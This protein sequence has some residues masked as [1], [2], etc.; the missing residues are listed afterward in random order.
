MEHRPSCL[1]LLEGSPARAACE[2]L[3]PKEIHVEIMSMG[4][5][6]LFSGS[7]PM[8]S[9][10]GALVDRLPLDELGVDGKDRCHRFAIVSNPAGDAAGSGLPG[11][12][13][14]LFD[15]LTPPTALLTLVSSV[16]P[17]VPAS[18][19]AGPHTNNPKYFEYVDKGSPDEFLELLSVCWFH[20]GGTFADVPQGNYTLVLEAKRRRQLVLGAR[21]VDVS[22]TGT[23]YE[24][25]A[26]QVLTE[27]FQD[28]D[29][30][31]LT[32]PEAGNVRVELIHTHG[33][34][35]RGICLKAMYLR[36]T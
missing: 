26:Q 16:L 11:N 27:E 32:H 13:E 31:N 36:P 6:T 33:N 25:D 30:A 3:V 8:D 23:K 10:F 14:L 24:W 17:K 21:K 2:A 20:V 5:S 19:I 22:V 7:V 12:L 15:R 34:W 1:P 35:K 4:G 29:V 28:F 9:T 18:R